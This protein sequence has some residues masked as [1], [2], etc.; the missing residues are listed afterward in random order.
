MMNNNRYKQPNDCIIPSVPFTLEKYNYY[1]GKLLEY[2]R[3]HLTTVAMVK[4]ILNTI[5][6]DRGDLKILFLSSSAT[7]ELIC[8][9]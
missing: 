1:R 8:G 3:E 9:D 2:V 6:V 4:Y 7:R 5:G